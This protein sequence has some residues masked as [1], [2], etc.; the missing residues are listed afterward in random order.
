MT[1]RTTS[2]EAEAKSAQGCQSQGIR[3]ACLS[4]WQQRH[5]FLRLAAISLRQ[6]SY[7]LALFIVYLRERSSCGLGRRSLCARV[8]PHSRPRTFSELGMRTR[9]VG[10]EQRGTQ[11]LNREDSYGKMGVGSAY[12]GFCSPSKL[13]LSRAAIGTWKAGGPLKV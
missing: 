4:L 11:G 6:G 10:L 9:D 5:K 2:S 12:W 8:G 7:Q 1:N 13:Q 3:H